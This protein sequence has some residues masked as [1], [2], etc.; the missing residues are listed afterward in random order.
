MTKEDEVEEKERWTGTREGWLV[1]RTTD[2]M[3]GGMFSIL[4]GVRRREAGEREGDQLKSKAGKGRKDEQP[5]TTATEPSSSGGARTEAKV[6]QHR[7]KESTASV[8]FDH[9]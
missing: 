7:L 2:D 3:G 6:S 4:K 8:Q 9:S 5:S 1:L